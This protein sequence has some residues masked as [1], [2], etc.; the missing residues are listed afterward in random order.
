MEKQISLS[1]FFLINNRFL[2]RASI[3]QRL[4]PAKIDYFIN[5]IIDSNFLISIP[6][7]DTKLK[8]ENGE[9][10]SIPR[11]ILQ[12]QQSQV[13]HFYKQHCAEVA[14]DPMSDRTVY[15][16]LESIHANK[17]KVVSGVD[18]FVKAASEG[19]EALKNTI[20]Q[21]P[22][23]PSAKKEFNI[24]LEDSRMY[25]KAKYTGHCGER[26]QT[27]THC[28]IYGLSDGNNPC[29]SQS[30]DHTHDLSCDGREDIKISCVN[31]IGDLPYCFHLDCLLVCK[32]FDKIEDCIR[33]VDDEE[34]KEELLYDYKLIWNSVFEL[35]AHRIRTAQQDQQKS[36]YLDKLDD[37]TA[38][39]TVD[40]SQ[41]ILPQ[42]FREGQAS[43]FG[44]RG[45]SLLVGSF[46]LRESSSGKGY[47]I[48]T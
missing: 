34:T 2:H 4:D 38:F 22:I 46:A 25:L 29:F 5:W 33:M 21:L 3:R 10:I 26:E 1:P 43:Y 6:W 11:Q 20:Q 17:Q 19:W 16:I 44:K 31:L 30:C 18:E 9:I 23:A 35:M 27:V 42:E 40:W 36:I 13:V 15:S 28:T 45:M 37:S 48:I 7:G 12:A 39:L 32:L 41:K 47:D 8:L 14:I 24:M